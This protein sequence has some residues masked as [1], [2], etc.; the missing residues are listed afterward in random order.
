MLKYELVC[1]QQHKQNTDAYRQFT[2]KCILFALVMRIVLFLNDVKLCSYKLFFCIFISIN[3]VLSIWGKWNK[4][5]MREKLKQYEWT[6]DACVCMNHGLEVNNY[7]HAN[8]KIHKFVIC[9]E[10]EKQKQAQLLTLNQL[11]ERT[12]NH[13]KGIFGIIS[14]QPFRRCSPGI[15]PFVMIIKHP[16][17]LLSSTY[18][19][20]ALLVIMKKHKRSRMHIKLTWCKV[21]QNIPWKISVSGGIVLGKLVK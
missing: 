12:T 21:S 18:W 17:K 16:H 11:P 5:K 19:P 8:Y 15:S 20:Y 9:T 2:K 10:K 14:Y 4:G 7:S 6:K 1:I 13:C 3:L